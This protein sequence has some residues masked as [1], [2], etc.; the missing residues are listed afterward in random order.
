ME[1]LLGQIDF[2]AL[3]VVTTLGMYFV[4]L[5]LYHLGY[6]AAHRQLLPAHTCPPSEPTPDDRS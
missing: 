3:W 6:Q 4:G 2:R 5:H 1:Q